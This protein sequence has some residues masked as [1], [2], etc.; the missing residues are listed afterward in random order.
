MKIEEQYD[1]LFKY[2]YMKTRDIHVAEDITQETFWSFWIQKITKI[3]T[4]RL[5]HTDVNMT[6]KVYTHLFKKNDDIL[7]DY[8]EESSQNLLKFFKDNEG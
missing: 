3:W 6:L 2:C 5:G 4:R 8:L 1:K 7:V